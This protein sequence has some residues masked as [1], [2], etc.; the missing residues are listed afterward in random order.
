M[1][2]NLGNLSQDL[3]IFGA[4]EAVEEVSTELSVD[5]L[6][7]PSEPKVDEVLP[8]WAAS[9]ED[10]MLD[11]EIK[12][13]K[14]KDDKGDT[15]KDEEPKEPKAEESGKWGDDDAEMQKFIDDLLADTTEVED[16]VEE[17]KEVAE[18][19]WDNEMVK[20]VGEL[21]LLL[22]EKNSKI[23]EQ[24]RQIEVTNNRFLEKVGEAENF[25]VYKDVIEKLEWDSKLMM[26]VKHKDTDNE[27]VKDRITWV[28]TDI[29]FDLTWQDV[30]EL[31]DNKVKDDVAT[32]L[33]SPESSAPVTPTIA[34][35]E[36]DREIDFEESINMLF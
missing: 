32:A 13:D 36:E 18:D 21:E 20:I 9:E 30:S 19:K 35:E 11:T 28:V 22:A 25:G 33:G 10:K 5:D 8:D 12:D 1:G 16:K 29:L 6:F 2:D 31:L 4:P 34:P 15:P 24:A 23:E 27:K 7:W 3:D 26:L 14:V 17:I